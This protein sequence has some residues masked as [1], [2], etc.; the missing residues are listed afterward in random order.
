MQAVSSQEL[1]YL[2]GFRIKRL[3]TFEIIV[4]IQDQNIFFKRTIAVDEQ[5]KTFAMVHPTQCQSNLAESA[6]NL[7]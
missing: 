7:Y 6:L 3:E 1:E 5:T 4:K 2:R